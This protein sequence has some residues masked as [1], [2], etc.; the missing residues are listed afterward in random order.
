MSF[1]IILFTTLGLSEASKIL[2]IFH[3]PSKSH[4]LLAEPLL[5]ELAR[6]G[7][8]VTI[9]TPF[10]L[11]NQQTNIRCIELTDVEKYYD[12]YWEV[13][14]EHVDDNPLQ[15]LRDFFGETTD[16]TRLTLEHPNV[17]KLLN[18]NE[19]FDLVFFEIFLNDAFLGFAH[20]Y[21]C[22]AICMSTI[23]MTPWANDLVRTPS[24]MSFIPNGLLPFKD[25]MTFRERIINILFTFYERYLLYTTY[26]PSQN[27]MYNSVFPDPKPSFYDLR[28][29]KVALILLNSHF[30]LGFPRPL[31]PNIIEVGGMQ[32]NQK[33]DSLP[34]EIKDF[35][36]SA[37]H[38]IVFFSMGSNIWPSRMSPEK[39][40]GILNSF[41]KI[42]LKVIWKWDDE[43]LDLDKNKFL[44]RKWLPQDS[45]LA[46]PNVKL[47]ITHGGLLSCIESIFHG[48]PMLGTPVFGDQMSNMDM[49]ANNH[50]GIRIDYKNLTEDSLDWALEEILTNSLYR[51]AV[52]YTKNLFR[53]Q[54]LTPLDTAKFWVE[55][56][57]RH[58]GATHMKSAAMQMSIIEYY[59][60]DAYTF[61]L[62][63]LILLV[64]IL[65]L[66]V[67]QISK[68]VFVLKYKEK[69]I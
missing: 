61:L 35:M 1:L 66:I 30:S 4:Q 5:F 19:T 42:K 69:V 22:P 27:E 64:I 15:M 48:V 38:G 2:S 33:P 43:K 67:F 51:K 63:I 54:P 41:N 47:F 24:P 55:Y 21:N 16:L 25:K 9:L 52:Q 31:M 59:N 62:I 56:V 58:K 68:K 12:P 53:D 36:D 57:I 14:F 8:E 18:S 6:S 34:K 26:L 32:I 20:Y 49:V 28:N 65:P 13:A 39:R 3:T 23:G 40:E 45:I 29:S 7:H 44:V 10:P 17:R 50:W 46:H 11:K 60:L 37:K